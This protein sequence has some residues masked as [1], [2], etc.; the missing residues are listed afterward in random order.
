LANTF[1][2]NEKF[3][4]LKGR[5]AMK[6]GGQWLRYDQR[7]FYAGNNGLLGF[8][9]YNGAFTGYAFADFLLDLSSSKGRGGGD[10][11][12]PWTHF[13]NRLGVFAQDDFKGR[14]NVT[15]NLGL[16]WAYTSPL[17]EKDNR[18][19]NFDL[20]T[21]RQILATDGSIEDRALYKPYYRGF[22]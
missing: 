5:H 4:W 16:R 22:E 6:L 17:V 7:R 2:I 10:P 8:I 20:V 1:Q 3:T 19:T 18:Q 15:L 9:A 11:S 14:K 13:Q 21:G 12:D